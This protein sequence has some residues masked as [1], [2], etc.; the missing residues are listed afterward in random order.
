[1]L[2]RRKEGAK[3]NVQRDECDQ[4]KEREWREE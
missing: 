2:R 3:E 1:M 4:E